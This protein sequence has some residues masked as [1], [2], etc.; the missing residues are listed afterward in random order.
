MVAPRGYVD[1]N[2]RPL[3][4]CETRGSG[5]LGTRL[6]RR[7][8]R[9]LPWRA[10]ERH[11]VGRAGQRDHAAADAGGPGRA[12]L[13]AWLARWPTPADL[14]ARRPGDAVRMWGK[15]GYPRRALRLWECAVV[16]TERFGGEVPADVDAL[17]TLP[18]VGHYT[19]RAVAAFA[20]RPAPPG[21]RHQRAPGDRPRGPRSGPSRPSRRRPATTPR[22]RRCCRPKPAGGGAAQRGADGTR[23]AGLH[24]PAPALRVVPARRPLRLARGRR[25]GARRAGGDGRSASPAPTARCAACCSTCFAALTIRSTG[26]RWTS[27]GRIRCSA[28]AHSTRSSSTA[29]SIR[30][31]TVATPC[32]ASRLRT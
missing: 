15:L 9:D 14:A 8:A 11:P 17:L 31:P 2:F 30:C 28:S 16:L 3:A 5:D 29:W 24:G 18:G 20:Y 25:A 19:A 1:A 22:S 26:P 32:R 4:G 21:G 13:R 23:R 10:A 27:S 6:V 12:G 7:S